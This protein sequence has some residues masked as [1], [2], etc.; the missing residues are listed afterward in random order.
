[1]QRLNLL[2]SLLLLLGEAEEF[3]V[4]DYLEPDQPP[5]NGRGPREHSPQQPLQTPGSG[6]EEH[7][8][9]SA[10]NYFPFLSGITVRASRCP[11]FCATC[12]SP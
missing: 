5:E 6:R 11:V 9:L 12:A 4:P 8:T 2:R 10:R 1:M 3:V 7:V